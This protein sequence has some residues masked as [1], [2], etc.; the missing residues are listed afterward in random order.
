MNSSLLAAD[1][2]DAA[3]SKD[4]KKAGAAKATVAKFAMAAESAAGALR[5]LACSPEN[6]RRIREAD[7]FAVLLKLLEAGHE[8]PAAQHG[9]ASLINLLYKNAVNQC[10]VLRT[11]AVAKRG[12][13]AGFAHLDKTLLLVAEGQPTPRVRVTRAEME[14][15]VVVKEMSEAAVLERLEKDLDAL[16]AQRRKKM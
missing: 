5:N 2:V 15:G 3:K 6:Q 10:D 9:A 16:E 1:G 4:P 7:G 13:P 11:F 8:T 14:E 12:T